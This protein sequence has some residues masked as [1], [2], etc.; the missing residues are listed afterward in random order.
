[1]WFHYTMGKQTFATLQTREM[2]I[3]WQAQSGSMSDIYPGK[4]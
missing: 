3:W 4:S 1:M 2:R